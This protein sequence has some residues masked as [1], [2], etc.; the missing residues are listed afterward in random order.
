MEIKGLKVPEDIPIFTRIFFS[1][2]F[3]SIKAKKVPAD[4]I[5]S[6]IKLIRIKDKKKS[7]Q[8]SLI[9]LGKVYKISSFAAKVFKNDK[10]CLVRSFI[11]LKEAIKL[12]QKVKMIIGVKK[13]DGDLDGHS[14]ICIDGEPLVEKREALLEYTVM[15]EY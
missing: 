12:N 13:T 10:P 6:K 7:N 11:L 4:K 15:K 9:L 3:Y 14:W 1:Y 5:V 2:I 8:K